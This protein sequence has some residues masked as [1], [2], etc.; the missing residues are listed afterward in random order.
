VSAR[1]EPIAIDLHWMGRSNCIAAWRVG[2][3]LVDCGPSTTVTRLLAELGDWRPR[4][5]LLTHVHFDHAGAAGALT[6]RWPDLEIWVHRRGARHLAAPERLEASA[7]RVFGPEFDKRF[8]TLEPVPSM[9]L[10][11]LDGGELWRGFQ[12]LD[13][14]GHASHHLTFIDRSG[15]AFVGDVSGVRLGPGAPVLL[16]T[17]PPDV[18]LTAWSASIEAVAAWHPTVLALPHFGSVTEP[19][20]HLEATRE[21][22]ARHREVAADSADEVTYTRTIRDDLTNAGVGSLAEDYEM[23]V[24]LDQNFLGLQRSLRKEEARRDR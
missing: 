10:H 22:L 9:N 12:V 13:T 17:P 11:A 14:P 8:G 7:R 23:V 1:D 4:A 6:R 19:E 16:P 24:P 18:D 2:E 20:P 5:L 3:V 15:W 21:Q